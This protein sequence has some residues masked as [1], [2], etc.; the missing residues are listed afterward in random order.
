MTVLSPEISLDPDLRAAGDRT[1]FWRVPRYRGL[2]CLRA[3]FRRY[4]YARHTHETYA[5]AA[6]MEGCETFF[7]RGE[8]RYAGPGSVA[9]VCPDE[10]HDGAP[11]GGG[12]E[13]R[14]FYPSVELMRE[15]A[16][17]VAGRPLSRAPWFPRSVV[18]DPELALAHAQLHACLSRDGYW[19]SELEQDSRL[20]DYLGR[21]IARWADLDA[22]P[23]QR[24]GT[25]GITRARDYLD[26]HLGQEADLAD[27]ARLAGLSRSHFIRAFAKETG[28]TPHAYLVDR[29]FRAASR[30][31]S[32]G[33]APGDVAAVCGFF[34]QSHLN[35]VFKARM[36][37]TPGTYRAA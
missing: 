12:F 18:D 36:G 30:L 34:D 28:F 7:H 17:D 3:T 10:I 26:A 2:D 19:A 15:I 9:I 1:H 14:T 23:A 32:R 22:V 31:L 8:Q 13:Y 20:I 5:L 6:I 4:S 16:E 35:R 11:Y 37:V 27:L 24:Y 21:L 29:R 25:Q 33:E